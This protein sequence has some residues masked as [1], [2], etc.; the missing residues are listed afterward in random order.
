MADSEHGPVRKISPSRMAG[1]VRNIS[2]SRIAEETDQGPVRKISHSR[3]VSIFID[4]S[5]NEV[6][7][8]DR[9]GSRHLPEKRSSLIAS[10]RQSDGG[11]ENVAF[12]GDKHRE[13]VNFKDESDRLSGKHV[14]VEFG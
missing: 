7:S 11:I 5:K 3:K 8:V 4:E 6:L 12:E 1:P 13:S 14:S 2:S 9:R 10:Y